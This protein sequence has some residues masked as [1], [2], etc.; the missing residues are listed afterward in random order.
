MIYS[1]F[2]I[3]IP[4]LK[5]MHRSNSMVPIEREFGTGEETSKKLAQRHS[6]EQFRGM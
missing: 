6:I 5:S 2:G 3:S 4:K 1:R